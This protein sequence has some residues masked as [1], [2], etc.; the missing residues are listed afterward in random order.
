VLCLSAGEGTPDFLP[1]DPSVIQQE[2]DS[3]FVTVLRARGGAD[4]YVPTTTFY[5]AF[6]DEI[7]EPQQGVLASAYLQDGRGVGVL[8][9][10]AQSV[11]AGQLAGSFYGH[12]GM[13]FNPLT[14]A[15]I[16]DALTHPGPA[17]LARI[18]LEEVCANYIAP[19]LSV[20]D[21]I[22]TSAEI[23]IAGIRLLAYLPKLIVEPPLMEYA[24]S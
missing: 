10:E 24:T 4:A 11:C 6:L 3:K 19:G 20:A 1:C 15:L 14:A 23:I 12:A 8:N 17:S 5:S 16:E 18:N 22:A 13:L 2:Y 21:A 7:V 9:V